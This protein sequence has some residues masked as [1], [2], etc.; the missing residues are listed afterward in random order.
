MHKKRF[1]IIDEIEIYFQ[2][3]SSA[4]EKSFS[5]DSS[6][7]SEPDSETIDGESI[8]FESIILQ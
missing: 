8:L 7:M 6:S 2:I 4:L 5:L 1:D 3:E